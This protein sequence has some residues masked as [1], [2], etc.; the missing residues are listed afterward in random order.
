VKPFQFGKDQILLLRNQGRDISY[1]IQ[2]KPLLRAKIKSHL[3]T[4]EATEDP[5]HTQVKRLLSE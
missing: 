3:L 1:H 4:K 2:V 5:D